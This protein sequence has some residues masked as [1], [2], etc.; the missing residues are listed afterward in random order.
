MLL[1]AG[2]K[3]IYYLAGADHN[4]VATSPFLEKLAKNGYEVIYFTNALDEYVM[5]HLTEYEDYKLQD[6][7]KED[8]RL[9]DKVRRINSGSGFAG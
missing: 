1:C 9:D 8:V 2:Q 7:S 3:S 5:Q 4:E 6:A